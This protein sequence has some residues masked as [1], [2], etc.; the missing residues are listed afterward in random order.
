VI[1]VLAH[2][3]YRIILS[4]NHE[5]IQFFRQQKNTIERYF[6]AH[7]NTSTDLKLFLSSPGIR[8]ITGVIII[9]ETADIM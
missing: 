3:K 7:L 2:A 9:S 1:V 6:N 4:H 5:Q 8:P